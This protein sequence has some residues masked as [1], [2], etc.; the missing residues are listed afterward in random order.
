MYE[1]LRGPMMWIAFLVFIFGLIYQAYNLIKMTK[2]SEKVYY[3]S[4]VK[5][6][7]K[8]FKESL[9]RILSI[10]SIQTWNNLRISIK[11]TI[12]GSQP[13]LALLTSVFHLCIIITPVFLVGHNILLFQSWGLS[14]CTFSESTTDILTVIFLGCALILIIRRIFVPSVRSVTSLYDYLLLLITIAPFLTGYIAYHQLIDYRTIIIIHIIAG[15]LMLLSIGLTKLGH[16]I[17]F[18]FV[19]FFIGSEYSFRSGSRKW[20]EI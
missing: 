16:M 3:T 8:T 9:K 7:G 2:K 18:F 6:K 20:S 1:F 10:P 12:L 14:L 15:E 5:A 13:M 4:K 17:F 19:R 11:G